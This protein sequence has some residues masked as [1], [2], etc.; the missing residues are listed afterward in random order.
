MTRG[1]PKPTAAG[2]TFDALRHKDFGY[3]LAGAWLSNAGTWLQAVAQG[4]L[5]TQLTG[6]SFW[7]GMVGF[8]GG[9]PV[10]F[11]ALPA[12]LLAD[13]FDR[14]H[15]LI[16]GQTLVMLL[17]F[18]LAYVVQVSSYSRGNWGLM[19]WILVIAFLSGIGMALSF[20]AWQAMIP[21]LVP[22]ETLLN[23]V[24][25]NSAQFHAARLVGPAIAGV[26]MAR[27]GIASAFWANAVSFLAV[28]GVLFVIRPHPSA[29]PRVVHSATDTTWQRLTGGVTYA[30]ENLA[31]AVLLVSV[32]ITTFFGLPYVT[33]LPLLVQGSLHGGAD[34]YAYLMAANGLGALAGALGVAYLARVAHRPTLI[35]VGLLVFSAAAIGIALSRSLWLTAC[36]MPLAGAAFLTMQSAVNTALQIATPPSVRGRVMALFVLAFLGVMPIGSLAFGALGNAIGVPAAIAV[37]EAVCLAWGLVLLLRPR[38]LAAVE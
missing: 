7:V 29:A 31:V 1:D 2:R 33:L 20:P 26:L 10:L 30:R 5:V 19:A 38:L 12:G 11:L 9:L 35:R 15:L 27:L 21:D 4:W 6:S 16:A 13:R 14:R 32:S 3:F 28:I 22:P 23:A 25:L 18:V 36:L 17:A 8:A 24:S 34:A 37:G